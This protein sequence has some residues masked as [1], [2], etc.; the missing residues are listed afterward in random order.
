MVI[1]SVFVVWVLSKGDSIEQAGDAERKNGEG[2]ELVSQ[3]GLLGLDLGDLVGVAVLLLFVL[4][5]V[6]VCLLFVKD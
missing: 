2:N 6:C 3:S 4:H 1:R 5:R